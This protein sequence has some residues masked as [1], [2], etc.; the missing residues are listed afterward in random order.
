MKAS[1]NEGNSHGMEMTTRIK[2]QMGLHSGNDRID[3]NIFECHVLETLHVL[4][5]NGNIERYLLTG[6]ISIILRREAPNTFFRIS[7]QN[8]CE[9]IVCNEEYLKSK[10]GGYELQTHKLLSLLNQPVK[11]LKYQAVLSVEPETL[12]ILIKPVWKIHPNSAALL[13][14][15]SKNQTLLKKFKIHSLDVIA[16]VSAIQGSIQVAS[17]PPAAWDAEDLMLC[18]DL[19][20]DEIDQLVAR[21]DVDGCKPRTTQA[22]FR[23]EGHLLSAIDLEGEGLISIQKFVNSGSY[24]AKNTIL[25]AS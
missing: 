14:S 9:Q 10:D 17:N 16:A 8:H 24:G 18:W 11:I 25:Y 4:I 22:E 6:E 19:K 21:F 12:P 15:V 20:S 1:V 2:G 5:D 3:D 7:N 13:V 23:L